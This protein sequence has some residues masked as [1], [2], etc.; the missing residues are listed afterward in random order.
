MFVI[1][2]KDANLVIFREE[3]D[4]SAIAL[5]LLILSSD[6][7]PSADLSRN[8]LWS[9]PGKDEKKIVFPIGVEDNWPELVQ[10]AEA[11]AARYLFNDS[12]LRTFALVIAYNKEEST[13]RFLVFHRGGLSASEP[14]Q[15]DIW[16]GWKGFLCL[17]FSIL[18]WETRGDAGW[19]EWSNDARV[20]LPGLTADSLPIIFDIDSVLYHSTCT[21]GRAPHVCSI[22]R[23]AT[24]KV[25]AAT[26]VTQTQGTG[27]SLRRRAN[28]SKS[29]CSSKSNQRRPNTAPTSASTINLQ[30]NKAKDPS[31]DISRNPG[32]M[33]KV[34]YIDQAVDWHPVHPP[35][36][37]DNV[38]YVVK[39]SWSHFVGSKNILIEGP[40]LRDCGGMFGIPKHLYSFRVHHQSN[41]P[42]TNHL[43][44]PPPDSDMNGFRWSLFQNMKEEEPD[45]RS[46]LN[47]VMAFAGHSLVSAKDFPSLIRA[48]LHAHLGY[49]NIC[50]QG[51]QHR[52]LSIGNVLMVDEPIKSDPFDILNPDEIQ[53]KILQLVQNLQ[54]GNDCTGFVIDEDM[55]TNWN[56]YFGESHKGTQSG[57]SDFMSLA[58]LAPHTNSYWHSPLDDYDS[59]FY[60]VQW[61]CVFHTSSP[62]D[63]VFRKWVRGSYGEREL[64]KTLL[65]RTEDELTVSLYGPILAQAKLFLQQWSESFNPL[66]KQCAKILKDDG[67]NKKTF[68]R[69]ADLGL[70]SF[71]E[72]VQHHFA[73]FPPAVSTLGGDGQNFMHT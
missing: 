42:S 50:Q 62:D 67:A 11:Y 26:P 66:S 68:R 30:S 47:H 3:N 22:K 44:L 9:P 23:L 45:Y 63:S 65:F 18:T 34:N 53:G 59:L 35:T 14:L 43:Y 10:R 1:G 49:Y 4:C 73:T 52:D 27:H 17:I 12:P 39:Y 36:V 20:Y 8:F 37:S 5:T 32:L 6:K 51:Y 25:D 15:L 16:E 57:T 55:A 60:V 28:S 46:L 58:L 72:V 7:P 19:P 2:R 33:N 21:Q 41:Y 24:P 61:A 38:S 13:V 29:L 48:I 64:V 56:T 54:I 40:L 69:I 31:N 70:Q 71:L